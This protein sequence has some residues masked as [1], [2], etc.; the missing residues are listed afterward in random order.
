MESELR[1]WDREKGIRVIICLVCYS[2][3]RRQH[4]AL[5]ICIYC[6]DGVL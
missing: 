2:R 3:Y 1:H 4:R 6:D 5:S